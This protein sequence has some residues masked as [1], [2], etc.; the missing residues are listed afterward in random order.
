MR[1]MRKIRCPGKFHIVPWDSRFYALFQEE[2]LICVTVYKTG[3][4]VDEQA[5]SPPGFI[6]EAQE[7]FACH[8][9]RANYVMGR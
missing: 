4:P 2:E 9:F 5:L 7:D 1:R 6:G 3:S 8:S